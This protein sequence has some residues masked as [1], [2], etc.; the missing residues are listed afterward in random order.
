MI[1][2]ATRLPF[3]AL[4]LLLW[5]C[6]ACSGDEGGGS[7]RPVVVASD[8]AKQAAQRANDF[9]LR[10]WRELVKGK[11]SANVAMSGLS[12]AMALALFH[13]ACADESQQV[14]AKALGYGGAVDGVAAAGFGDL[15]AVLN[16]RTAATVRMANAIYVRGGIDVLPKFLGVAQQRFGA[17]A[18]SRDFADPKTLDAIN[19]WVKQQT[20]GKIPTILERLDPQNFAVLLNALFF[21]GQWRQAFRA[22]RTAMREF[23]PEVGEPF[24]VAMMADD[25]MA[26]TWSDGTIGAARLPYRGD[27][28]SMVVMMP[29]AGR[30]LADLRAELSGERWAQVWAGVSRSAS[31]T[32]VG[33]PKFKVAASH[34]LNAPLT[35]LGLGPALEEGKAD[36]SRLAV[37]MDARMP[38][39]ATVTQKVV[40][41]VD[42]V[43]TEAAAVTSVMKGETSAMPSP[44]RPWFDRP[45]LFAIVEHQTGA[46]LF[47]G[48]ITDPRQ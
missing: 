9:G 11:E 23:M 10:L 33:L 37:G 21:K 30:R 40:V 7:D 1:P 41:E 34:A 12:A 32:A 38:V 4:P 24:P 36:Y 20:E 48:Q 19:G 17:L 5:S 46:I 13:E 39:S 6:A 25:V 44:F 18:E 29:L 3:C 28:Y 16:G 27:D 35:A 47:L 15:L 8:L 26:A 42:E 45:F 22:E 2:P 14:V 31:E 43:G